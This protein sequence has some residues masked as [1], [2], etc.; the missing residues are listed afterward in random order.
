MKG[1]SV[2][3]NSRPQ[4]SRRFGLSD[5]SSSKQ[6]LGRVR[7]SAFRSDDL[8][9]GMRTGR[10]RGT[11]PRRPEPIRR[12]IGSRFRRAVRYGNETPFSIGPV[13]ARSIDTDVKLYEI[14]HADPLR[15]DQLL[16]SRTGTIRS[17]LRTST[18]DHHI[19][20]DSIYESM[21]V[22]GEKNRGRT[23]GC[24]TTFVVIV[25]ILYP[26]LIRTIRDEPSAPPHHLFHF[27]I[28]CSISSSGYIMTTYM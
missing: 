28:I 25:R 13:R 9:C 8:E 17:R 3:R 19:S 15:S 24:L 16:L 6:Y 4:A 23:P 22:I 11:V 21:N 7:S 14:C 5:Y 27:V 26:V 20:C 18:N 2:S 10:S 12:S 1:M